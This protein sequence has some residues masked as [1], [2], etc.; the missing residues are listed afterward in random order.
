MVYRN[1][2]GRLGAGFISVC[3]KH[4]GWGSHSV[5]F[6]SR[7]DP[8]TQPRVKKGVCVCVFDL[9]MWLMRLIY[10][11]NSTLRE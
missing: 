4:A 3:L 8:V 1:S 9:G 5:A 2:A 11:F 6:M 10:E 7:D